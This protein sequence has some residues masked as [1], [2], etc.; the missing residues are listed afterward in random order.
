LSALRRAGFAA[1]ALALSP[2]A[3]RACAIC[4]GGAS[5]NKGLIDGFW[6]AIIALLT[7]TMSL[8][9]AIGWTMWS[10]ENNR[11]RKHA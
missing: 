8:L 9:A 4:F 10:I 5:N 1:A 3:A 6:W 11:N 2:R 7:V